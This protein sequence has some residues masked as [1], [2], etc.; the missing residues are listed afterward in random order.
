MDKHLSGADALASGAVD[1][2]VTMVTS[3]AGGP[4]TAVVE[5]IIALTL[6]ASVRVEWTSNEKVAMEMAFGA[7]VGGERA[8]LCVKSVGLNI[9]M[10]PLM[11]LA[12]CG[13]NAGFVL[14]VGDD[15]GAWASQN[16]QDS[17]MLALASELPVLEPTT[18]GDAYRAMRYGFELSEAM[19]VPVVIRVTRALVAAVTSDE[20]PHEN[21]APT[22]FPPVYQRTSMRWV[23]LPVNAVCLH[24]QLHKQL[25]VVQNKWE[26]S[27][28]NAVHGDGS[29]GVLAAGFAYQKL[30][31]L[32]GGT[33]PPELRV[34]R[35][36]TAHPIPTGYLVT[37]LRQV[38]TALVL[39]ETMPL[40]ERATRSLAQQAG[41][42]L[43]IHGRDT[44]HVPST[45]E[46]SPAQIAGALGRLVPTLKLSPPKA[47]SRAMPSRIPLCDGCPYIP[48]FDAL[49]EIMAEWGGRD[50]FIVVG[51]PGCMAR[52]QLPPYELMDVK[53]SL[54]SSIGIAAGIALSQGHALSTTGV[55][56]T[57]YGGAEEWVTRSLEDPDIDP[58]PT[59][60]K[61]V[62]ALSGDSSFLHTGLNGLIDAVQVSAR[63]LVVILDNGTTALSG[64]QPHPGSHIDA[65]GRAKPGL[66]LAA[67]ARDTGAA[68]VQVV[69]IDRGEEVRGAIE[70]GI[71]LDGVAVII[72]RGR[73]PRYTME[74]PESGA[75]A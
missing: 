28:L 64:G 61:R 55:P 33:I 17:R 21:F 38:T 5:G 32:L 13:C 62:I 8:L 41:L 66:D 24:R 22:S 63:M 71:D 3:Y 59:A 60:G 35:L 48:T 43:P 70:R 51:D 15:P 37:F 68:M 47:A 57:G 18:I 50:R 72:A 58:A 36:G 39:E 49:V 46:L 1:A 4:V 6:P 52:S 65:R 9:A 75:A 42:C 29:Y 34:L 40:I 20:L 56:A 74:G 31:D 2:G 45:G 11:T 27:P 30:L 16:E 19:H 26:R 54:G 44:G 67:L 73:C 12:L 69:N 10:D 53:I 23:S 7:S 25:A 14:L